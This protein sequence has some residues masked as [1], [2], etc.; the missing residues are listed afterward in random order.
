MD[1][2][3]VLLAAYDWIPIGCAG[4]HSITSKAL[5]DSSCIFGTEGPG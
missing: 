3:D 1:D 2:K 5:V 4:V